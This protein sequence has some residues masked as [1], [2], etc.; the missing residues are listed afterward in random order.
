MESTNSII[1]KVNG[2]TIAINE[3]MNFNAE[4]HEIQKKFGEAYFEMLKQDHS[5]WNGTVKHA[6]KDYAGTIMNVCRRYFEH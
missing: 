2:Q 6:M 1:N 3:F 5:D 4:I